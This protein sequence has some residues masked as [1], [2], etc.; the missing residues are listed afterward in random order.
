MSHLVKKEPVTN[1]GGEGS[2]GTATLAMC[3]DC[4]TKHIVGQ[5][6]PTFFPH[7]VKKEQHQCNFPDCRCILHPERLDCWSKALHKCNHPKKPEYTSP[8]PDGWEE[9]FDKKLNVTYCGNKECRGHIGNSS[10]EVLEKIK[11]FIRQELLS[12]R[13][14]DARK[15]REIIGENEKM[16]ERGGGKKNGIVYRRNQMRSELRTALSTWEEKNV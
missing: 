11:D 5:S 13:Q 3:P 12:T 10:I 8:R 4:H 2:Y 9:R 7:P 1:R 15:F 14:E 16:P 6:C